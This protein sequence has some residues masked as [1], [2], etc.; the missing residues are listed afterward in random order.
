MSY[1]PAGCLGD[2]KEVDGLRVHPKEPV[3]ARQPAT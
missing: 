3:L 2:N 1:F